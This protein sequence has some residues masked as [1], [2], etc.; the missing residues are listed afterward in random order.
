MFKLHV[1]FKL[2]L[3]AQEMF[4]TDGNFKSETFWEKHPT[5]LPIMKEILCIPNLI[6]LRHN[7]N[8]A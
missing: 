3:S 1:E 4:P 8:N 2:I 6:L 7:F 5:P